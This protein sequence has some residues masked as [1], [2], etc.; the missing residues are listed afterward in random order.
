MRPTPASDVQRGIWFTEHAGAAHAGYHLALA[1]WFDGEPDVAALKAACAA[2]VAHHEV[3]GSAMAE[4]DGQLV[5]VPA[6]YAPSLVKADYSETF[7][8]GAVARPFDLLNGP[9]VRFEYASASPDRHVLLVVAHHLVFDGKSKDILVRELAEAYND[10]VGNEA[11]AP[12]RARSAV[13]CDAAAEQRQRI[14]QELVPAQRYWHEHWRESGRPLLPGLLRMPLVAEAGTAHEFELDVDAVAQ[15][16]LAAAALGVT[17]FD[18]LLSALYALL[19]RYGNR[20]PVV[21]VD[22]NTRGETT[23]DSIGSFV[24]EL[25]VP[26]PP[27]DG[28]NTF[29]QFASDVHAALR[30]LYQ[31]RAVPLSRVVSGLRPRASLASVSISY[32]RCDATGPTFADVRAAVSWTVFNHTA[33]NALHLHVLDTSTT[34]AVSLHYSPSAIDADSIARIG[35]HLQT[36]VAAATAQ[37]QT[38]VAELPL[39]GPEER[40]RIL[41]EWNRT[42]R[43]YPADATLLSLFQSQVWATPDAEAAIHAGRS[44][45]FRQLNAMADRLAGRLRRHGVM[46]GDLVGICVDRSVTMLVALLAVARAGAAHVPV[47]PM[48]P[49]ARRELIL[50]DSQPVLVLTSADLVA[51]VPGGR[52]VLTVDDVIDVATDPGPDATTPPM[53]GR[54]A[55]DV[56]YVMYT[57]GST[58]RPK[59]VAVPDRALVNLLLAMR[60]EVRPEPGHRWLAHTSLA[61]DISALELLLPLVCGVPVVLAA[62]TDARDGAALLRLIREHR[63]THVQATPSGW[64]M[65]LDAGFGMSSIERKAVVALAGGEALPLDLARQL[66][67]RVR[68]LLNVYGPTETT[69]WS[70]S[71]DLPHPVDRI[72][73]G[74]PI[75]NTRVYLY[76]HRLQP[77][78]IGVP[79]ELYIGGA[80]LALGYLDQPDLTTER[81]IPDPLGP[82]G[83]ARLYRTGDLAM[84]LPDGSIEFRGRVDEQVKIR[85]HRIEPAEVESRLLEHPAIAQAVVGLSRDKHDE[86]CLVGY[87]VLHAHESQPSRS[88]LRRLLARMLP[89]AMIPVAWVVLDHMPATPNGK[90]DRAALP[91]PMPE[92]RLDATEPTDHDSPKATVNTLRVIWRECLHVDDVRTDDDLFDLGGHS[93]TVIQIMNRV[94]SELGVDVPLDAFYERPT[95]ADIAELVDQLGGRTWPGSSLG[96]TAGTEAKS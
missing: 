52:A 66:R 71:A 75:A 10:A 65:L 76:D 36:L 7:V 19:Y 4:R 29:H 74:R 46:P 20:S 92:R 30:E 23:R 41:T 13:R 53:P 27:I 57:S 58:G 94:S 67:G 2:V 26:A 64:R 5:M 82:P 16:D 44:W 22:L 47:D 6:A 73:I 38:P 45:T 83:G 14:E 33:R 18:V 81:F 32:R 86:P 89:D 93:L 69:V 42:E 12:P 48:Y 63:I 28:A 84:W 39:L 77:V 17:R 34:I 79:G 50:A 55:D 78:P 11:G 60:D 8:R 72:T 1:I 49:A 21:A 40:H 70:T 9:L 31:I 62:T 96:L 80:G 95:I 37:T 43:P 24:N 88:E 61:F 56:A 68:R 90:L 3:L 25:P 51:E 85:G 87:L 35:S 59:G 15:M 91:P 54:Q